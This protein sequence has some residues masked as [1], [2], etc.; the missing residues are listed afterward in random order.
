[1]KTTTYRRIR[2]HPAS[3]ENVSLKKDN[4]REQQFFGEPV[5]EPFF[6]PFAASHAEGNVQRKCA[7]CEKEE[8][9][10]QQKP[11][12]KETKAQLPPEKKDEEKIMKKADEKDKDKIHKKESAAPTATATSK[13]ANYIGSIDGKGQA[14]SAS[15]QSFYGS[16]MGYDFSD[17][18]VHTGKDASDSAKELN[19]RAYTIGN[20]IVFGEGQYN[21]ESTEGKK[22]MAHELTH[23]LQQNSDTQL[24]RKSLPEEPEKEKS[25]IPTFSE[26]SVVEQNTR[27]FADCNGVSV[28]GHTDANYGNSYSS[29]GTSAP[30]SDC[31]DCAV[32]ECVVNTGT[33]VSV[34]TANPQI[35]LPSV[36][37]GLNEC[38]Q[39][40]VQQFINTTLRAHELQHVAAFNTY[41]GTVRTPY[42][43]RGCASG[44]DAYTQQIHDNIESARKTASDARS[45]AL[46][47]NGA[48]IFN[49][50][51]NCPDPEPENANTSD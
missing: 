5:H 31:T 40:A 24:R 28:E 8:K 35:T 32:E 50:P 25:G 4:Q 9:Q 27:H 34:F 42:T 46:D 51:C 13:S 2:R 29:P 1:M 48:N 39:K 7:E 44:L 23:V 14:M 21:Q 11:N 15:S 22:L 38:E 16:R 41:R 49:V 36:P 26:R 17:V 30:A 6:K 19:A 12:M 20:H 18:K 3:R 43:Y 10:L 45:S 33:V 47:A 37:S